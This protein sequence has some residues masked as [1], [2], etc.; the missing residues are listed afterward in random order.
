MTRPRL[1]R[2]VLP[3]RYGIAATLAVVSAGCFS[4]PDVSTYYCVTNDNCPTGYYC[5]DSS[6]AGG[7]RKLTEGGLDGSAF[8]VVAVDHGMSSDGAGN[9]ATTGQLDGAWDGSAPERA[10]V[11]PEAAE[12]GVGVD[13]PLADVPTDVPLPPSD[14]ADTSLLDTSSEAASSRGGAGGNVGSGGMAATGGVTGTG[15]G[16]GG[17]V[18]TGGVPG[19]GGSTVTC[20]NRDCTSS[21][22]NNC[23]GIADNQESPCKVCVV[24]NSQSCTTGGLGICAVGTQ[25]CQLASDHQSVGYGTCQQTT[26]ARARDCT[27]SA[28]NDCNGQAD[29][30]ETT[31]C[32]CSGA[33]SP[34]SCSTGLLGICQAGTQA[35]VVATN[36]STSAWGTCTQLKAKGTETC[37][38][39]GADDDCDGTVDNVPT[40][41]CNVGNGIGAC[42][43]AGY[44][45]CSAGAEICIPL[46]DNL[47]NAS[48]WHTSPAPNGSWDWDCDGTITKQYP[49]ATPPP[50]TCSGLDVAACNAVPNL[51]YALDGAIPCGGTGATGTSYCFWASYIPACTNKTG[52]SAG[53]QQGC[54]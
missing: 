27:S 21:A 36:K 29:D 50:P 35:C 5:A 30:L 14:S 28:D 7:C 15:G 3:G 16:A 9:E 48:V 31:Y 2:G 25:T 17:V 45:D 24:D 37:A 44:T 22:D 43:N 34:R 1:D 10:P 49:D 26:P 42:A 19:T 33:S 52:Q 39:P 4:K 12:A 18:G 46:V 40:K 13:G 38:N 47:G 11:S 51:Y 54:R 23:N 6:K 41:T 8:D 53:N 20:G 32:Q